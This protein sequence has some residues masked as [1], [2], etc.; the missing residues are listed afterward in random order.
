MANWL[1]VA[2][3]ERRASSVPAKEHRERA[4]IPPSVLS[5][6]AAPAQL[7][8]VFE[9]AHTSKHHRHPVLIGRLDALLITDR[10]ARLN[11]GG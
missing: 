7:L 2:L 1:S 9:M 6:T 3:S 11:D 5:D 10:S 8:L 4:D